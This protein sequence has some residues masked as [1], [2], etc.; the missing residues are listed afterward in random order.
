M[1]VFPADSLA[2]CLLALLPPSRV[3]RQRV[4][5]G[6]AV[7]RQGD[8]SSAIFAV[9]NGCIRLARM[10]ADGTAL[11]LHVAGPGESFAEAALSAAAYHCDAVAE[12]DSVVLALSKSDL[13][14]ALAAKPDECLALTLTLA[15]QVRDL[16]ARLELRNVRPASERVLAWLQLHATGQPPCV[17]PQRSWTRIAEEMGLTRE[18]VYRALARLEQQGR[19]VRSPEMVRLAVSPVAHRGADLS[20]RSRR[21]MRRSV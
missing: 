6:G 18:A 17:N 8:P 7:F 20:N 5:R 16:R 3:I 21:N 1:V 11:V 14:A 4:D 2:A 19:I 10:Q 15:S 12:S 9:E 13:L